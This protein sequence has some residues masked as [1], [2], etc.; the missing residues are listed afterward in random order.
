MSNKQLLFTPGPTFIPPQVQAEISKPMI[1]HRSEE[2][3]NI[4][5]SLRNNLHLISQTDG[6]SVVLTASG[7][8][9]MEAVV[10]S[11]TSPDD[12]V[13]IVDAGKFG[14]RWVE[15]AKRYELKICTIVKPW[16]NAV[17]PEEILRE[18]TPNTKAVFVQACESS[19]G[20]YHPIEQIGKALQ[21]HPKILFVVDAIT[22]FGIYPLSQRT[23]RID[24]LV[25]SSQKALMCPPGLSVVCL[26]K[27]AI[28]KLQE[29]TTLYLS[30]AHELKSQIK[31]RPAFTPAISLVRGM[32]KSTSMIM[33]E[34]RQDVYK[35]HQ[36]LQAMTRGYMKALGFQLLAS[37][38]VAS[39][40]I[41]AVHSIS[42]IDTEKWLK[43]LRDEH[44]L[45][46][47]GGQDQYRGKIFRIAHMGYCDEND[48][49]QALSLIGKS[50]KK[51][52][53]TQQATDF[54]KKF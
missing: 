28:S 2:F 11:F 4:F 47:A 39:M 5:A 42:G 52:L 8:G 27:H 10:A 36:K 38:E 40:G 18:I 35:R 23:H 6:E 43:Q 51:T 48:L 7:T 13:V 46:L 25:A 32:E 21:D 49:K 45:W 14:N 9:A 15:I 24:V 31:N 26:S 34:G 37:D 16:G 3:E 33:N 41:T 44:Q 20:V 19:T 53:N 12:H 50:L 17:S 54:L 30:L 1:H 22:A 29:P